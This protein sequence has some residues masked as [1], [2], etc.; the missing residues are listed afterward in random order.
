MST[1][2]PAKRSRTGKGSKQRSQDKMRSRVNEAFD[3]AHQ[4]YHRAYQHGLVPLSFSELLMQHTHS[5]GYVD[6]DA[7]STM[8]SID[9]NEVDVVHGHCVHLKPR[10]GI[11]PDILEQHTTDNLIDC[12][13]AVLPHREDVL[14]MESLEFALQV[15]ED[16][17]GEK[18]IELG[19]VQTIEPTSSPTADDIVQLDEQAIVLEE[20]PLSVQRMET[21]TCRKV[22]FSS[23]KCEKKPFHS[24]EERKAAITIEFDLYYHDLD[25][26]RLDLTGVKYLIYNPP[27]CEL[28]LFRSIL[29]SEKHAM[30]FRKA[31]GVGRYPYG[32][33]VFTSDLDD[34]KVKGPNMIKIMY[35]PPRARYNS[36]CT[37]IN[38]VPYRKAVDYIP[39][40]DLVVKSTNR[41]EDD[42]FF[43]DAR[44]R[45]GMFS[46][47]LDE[48][49][50]QNT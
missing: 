6:F 14:C 24:Y 29:K 8:L 4:L 3:R 38:S 11:D 25:Y 22:K 32:A 42:F 18:P 12:D 19:T 44:F 40:V 15:E 39:H 30:V 28:A 16:E 50:V 41:M 26:K 47:P 46:F 35:L 27:G 43:L 49:C 33:T 20:V 9:L 5:N 37:S 21:S 45:K 13:N 7:I 2:Q 1:I 48:L 34:L 10:D 17:E 31:E 36:I 23:K